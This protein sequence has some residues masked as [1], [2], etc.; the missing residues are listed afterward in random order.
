MQFSLSFFASK[1]AEGKE[2]KYGQFLELAKFADENDFQAVWTPERH[3]HEF[4]GPFPNP[5]LMAAALSQITS[6]V[7]IRAG[8]V[9]IPLHSPIRIAEDWS[10][11]DNLTG[12]RVDIAIAV[13]WHPNDFA[14]AP[15]NF[16]DRIERVYSGVETIRKLW[17]GERVVV[18]N[19]VGEMAEIGIFPKPIQAELP[20]WMT[21]TRDLEVFRLAGTKGFNLLTGL[22]FLTGDQ[23]A[24]RIVAYREGREEAGLDPKAG[25]V[26]VMLHTFIGEDVDVVRK[27]V[28]DP[29]R[30]YLRSSVDLWKGEN[31][32]LEKLA[33]RGDAIEFAFRRYF[34]HNGLFGTVESCTERVLKLNEIGV[35]E[36]ACMVDFGPT[37]DQLKESMLR[38]SELRRSVKLS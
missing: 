8:S 31:K 5:S 28:G 4:G 12:G 1:S 9:V 37:T 29:L 38:L 30:D 21:C 2:S 3:F 33:R 24:E 18:A 19:G 35:D 27:T 34:T 22:I 23:L 25:T 14:I 11:A 10:V 32:S 17:A 13:G 7:R 26:T 20:M 6:N 15:G 36:I 16:Q